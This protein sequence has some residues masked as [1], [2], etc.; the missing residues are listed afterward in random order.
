[1]GQARLR[2]FLDGTCL[3]SLLTFNNFE[4]YL[5]AFLQALISFILDGAVVD[6]HV[7]AIFT[8]Y[9]T[10]SFGVVEPLYSSF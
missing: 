8:T 5:V 9:E 2:H 1:M 3:G 10:K 7:R 6:K 4:L